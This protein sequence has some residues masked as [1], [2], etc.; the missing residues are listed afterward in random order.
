MANSSFKMIIGMF[1]VAIV[2]VVLLMQTGSNVQEQTNLL[3]NTNESLNIASA[4]LAGNQISNVTNFTLVNA[5]VVTGKS[6]ITTVSVLNATGA[7]ITGNSDAG[8]TAGDNW[9]MNTTTGRIT[10]Q[11]TTYMV[12]GNGKGNTTLVTYTYKTANYVDDGTSRPI[13]TLILLFSALGIP[14]IIL[15]YI[16]MNPQVMQWLKR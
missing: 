11:N 14:V 8:L 2:G 3:T 1:I 5:P 7:S 10:F 6:A 13:I 4:R 12:T 15:A 16:F 9:T